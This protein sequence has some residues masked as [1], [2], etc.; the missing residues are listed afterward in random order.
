MRCATMIL[1]FLACL[2]W[3]FTS[4]AQDAITSGPTAAPVDAGLPLAA[5][6]AV[7][8]V[9]P[10]PTAPGAPIAPESSLGSVQPSPTETQSAAP[11]GRADAGASP[12]LHPDEIARGLGLLV[13]LGLGLLVSR[14]GAK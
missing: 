7:G 4:A 11:E 5:A 9:A 8:S 6:P 13:G 2:L 3:S 12:S 14:V 1:L 10:A